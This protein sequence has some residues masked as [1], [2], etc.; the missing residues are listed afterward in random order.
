MKSFSSLAFIIPVF[1]LLPLTAS[2]QAD[3]GTEPAAI[4]VHPRILLGAGGES[5][6]SHNIESDKTWST[7]HQFII[8]ESGKMLTK[9]PVERVLIGRRLL[10]KS[11]EALKRIFYLSYSYRMTGD[12]RYLTRAK[13][14][15][16]A[17]SAFS[18]WNP[19]HFLDVAEMTMAAAIG[20]DW[21]HASLDETTKSNVKTAIIEKGLRQSLDV[22][23]NSWLKATHNWNQVCNA[24]MTYGALAV[25]EDEP[26]M[27]QEIIDRALTSILLPMKDY[28]PDGAYPEGYGYWGYGTS[29]NVMFLSAV[30]LVFGKEAVPGLSE[31]FLATAGYLENM[32][33][34][35]GNS[36]NYSDAG[37]GGSMQ[38]AM[39]WFANRLGDPSL[40]WS[41]K[42]HIE[43]KNPP[44]DRLLPA[45]MIWG[46][47]LTM[48]K[49]TAPP[50]LIWSGQ[51]K[52]PVAMMRSSW[53]DRDAVYLALKAGS[54]SVN[55]GHMDVGSF[56][57][58]SGGVRWA[59]DFGMQDYNSLEQAGVNLWGMAQNS[60]RWQVFRYNNYVHNTLTVNNQLQQVKG[61][62]RIDG[63]SAGT[64][65]LNAKTDLTSL[66]EGSLKKAQRGVAI[67]DGR[68]VEVMDEVETMNEASTIRWTMLT[69][70]EVTI[71]GSNTAVL[72]KNGKKLTLLVK[73]PAVLTMK[74]W[75]TEP[76]NSWD[77]KN[78]GT[79]LV[80]FEAAVPANSKAVLKVLLLPE[81]VS[82]NSGVSSKTL[83]E[84]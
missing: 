79:I 34:P 55:H 13:T 30:E 24:G 45:A 1:L 82:E 7:I 70:A 5:A 35:N 10:D 21:L 62:S 69:P 58:E 64:L 57:M 31:G 78:P 18:D 28:E 84:W 38:P 68:Y 42:F 71:T 76:S 2:C 27:A 25:Y 59:M 8:N 48:D 80:G 36:F 81:G 19:S 66:Y 65:M 20:Y 74:T 14:E 72:S 61:S 17:I 52:N 67:V 40:L 75:S 54:P 39:F 33:G 83:A 15:L 53:T 60:Q 49:V 32:T 44:N 29:F 46:A 22:K 4:P 56:I 16:N 23:Y 41:E 50:Y 47:G 73:A 51:G 11:R 9:A 63:V 12:I 6:I 3:T 26:V 77:A 43:T 37:Q